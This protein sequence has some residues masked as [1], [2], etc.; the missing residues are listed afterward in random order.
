MESTKEINVLISG[1]S[2]AGLS[3]AY[4]L[5]KYGFK[6]TVVERASHIRP[7]GQAVD[8][9]G[10]VQTSDEGTIDANHLPDFGLSVIPF[11][12]KTYLLPQS[13]Q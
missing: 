10:I 5:T 9:R 12:L 6:V 8:V 7:G 13:N 1:A 4:C 2:I 11:S 3:T